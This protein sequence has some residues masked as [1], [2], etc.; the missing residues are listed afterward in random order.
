M[1]ENSQPMNAS[2]GEPGPRCYS[3]NDT[4][5]PKLPF[6]RAPRTINKCPAHPRDDTS[7]TGI[8]SSKNAI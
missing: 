3:L 4:F 7:I 2:G 1:Q 6:G 5:A 8:M